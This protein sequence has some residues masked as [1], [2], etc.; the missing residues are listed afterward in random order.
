MVFLLFQVFLQLG[1]LILNAL[2]CRNKILK[3]RTSKHTN[4]LQFVLT[5]NR[6]LPDAKK[7]VTKNWNILH[8]NQVFLANLS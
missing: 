5:Y 6:T 7:P 2:A 3:E 4:R 1:R 8:T